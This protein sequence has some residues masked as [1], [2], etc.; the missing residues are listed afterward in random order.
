MSCSTNR[1]SIFALAGAL[2]G[3][4]ALACDKPGND[5][6]VLGLIEDALAH[7][8][9]GI[10]IICDCWEELGEASRND[11]LDDQIL[12]SQRRC[13]ED[14]YLRDSEASR[15]YLE[16]LVPLRVELNDCLDDKLECS[17]AGPTGACFEDFDLGLESCIELPNSVERG[18]G[19]CY[20]GGGLYSDDAPADSEGDGPPTTECQPGDF[21]C[22]DDACIPANW[23]C[24]GYD[25]CSGGEDEAD[26]GGTTTEGP[27][28]ECD[29]TTFECG[30]GLCIPGQWEC[31]GYDDCSGGEDEADCGGTTTEGPSTECD[32][33]TFECGDGLCIPGE[34]ECDDYDDC[35]GG[36]DEA[37]CGGTAEGGDGPAGD[38][39]G[40]SD[41]GDAGDGPMPP[42]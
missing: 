5:D 33:T 26:C 17:D 13:I 6:A 10:A 41:G 14:A 28:T 27:S 37:D 1:L 36:E 7:E 11:C 35:A 40:E 31:D 29:D 4:G 22:A 18:L 20:A 2:L 15:I 19:D 3:P 32:D 12:P 8:N 39:G 38:E 16:C 21:V 42:G 30:D 9:D 25:D 23:E 34:W 24:D